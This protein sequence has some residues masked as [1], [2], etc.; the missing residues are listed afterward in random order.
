[1]H[2]KRITTLDFAALPDL[3]VPDA[4]VRKAKD[5]K[6][7]VIEIDS[8]AQHIARAPWFQRHILSVTK[9][10]AVVGCRTVK[11]QNASTAWCL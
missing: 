4:A 2:K 5:R 1:M 7:T 10:R 8:K 3:R 11:K 9:V 6:A